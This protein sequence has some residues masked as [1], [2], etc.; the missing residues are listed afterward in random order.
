MY[1]HVELLSRDQTEFIVVITKEV[2]QVITKIVN[3]MTSG[4][5]VLMLGR[6][7]ISHILKLHYFCKN[8]LFTTR[9]RAYN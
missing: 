8:L 5:G 1:F 6:D 3:F 9:H 4:V 2:Y 7:H